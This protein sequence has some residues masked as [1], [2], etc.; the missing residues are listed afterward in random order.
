MTITRRF[1]LVRFVQVPGPLSETNK[2]TKVPML[3]ENP[4]SNGKDNQ[5]FHKGK[6]IRFLSEVII[7]VT[8][9]C[10]SMAIL[11]NSLRPSDANMRQ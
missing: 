4:A 1:Q 6:T 2:G 7:Q 11:N 8:W 3:I 10:H 9:R 5:N